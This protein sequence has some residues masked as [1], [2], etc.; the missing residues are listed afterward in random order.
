[1]YLGSSIG[2]IGVIGGSVGG[3]TTGGITIGGI[4][5]SEGFIVGGSSEKLNFFLFN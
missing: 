2:G 3:I 5:G 4:V 1:M